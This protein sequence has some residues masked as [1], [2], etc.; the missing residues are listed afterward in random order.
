[1]EIAKF[2][3]LGYLVNLDAISNKI[4]RSAQIS[5]FQSCQIW[6]AQVT[7]LPKFH[8]LLKLPE[9]PNKSNIPNILNTPRKKSLV[10][11]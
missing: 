11:C 3:L 10:S 8:K 6:H 9:Y 2:V 4:G 1:M 5:L 7:K